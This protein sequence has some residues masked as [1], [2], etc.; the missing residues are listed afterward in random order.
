MDRF[1][2]GFCL[3]NRPPDSLPHLFSRHNYETLF[4]TAA[5]FDSFG[6][7]RWA[8]QI[9]F[10]RVV[11][12]ES[13]AYDRSKEAG[14]CT[15]TDESLYI[16]AIQTI[17][18]LQ[19]PYLMVLETGTTHEPFVDPDT[20]RASEGLCFRY[21]DRKLYEFI[22]Y[23]EVQNFFDNGLVFMVS[24]HRRRHGLLKQEYDR[25]GEAAKFKVPLILIDGKKQGR[26]VAAAYQQTDFL[27]SL[28]CLLAEG[29]IRL[30]PMQGVFLPTPQVSARYILARNGFNVLD[31]VNV[32]HRG[33]TYRVILDGDKTR[34]EDKGVNWPDVIDYINYKRVAHPGRPALK[35][36]Q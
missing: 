7:G 6:V 4:L 20:G 31:K 30:N 22:R 11:A 1:Q 26:T 28:R 8:E 24:D 32:L 25:W 18:S 33:Q 29:D 27:P 35:M 19:K 36:V 3:F 17:K 21:A 12:R 10:N 2:P 14:F 9:G 23:L 34:F 16:N 13:L 15:A 5:D